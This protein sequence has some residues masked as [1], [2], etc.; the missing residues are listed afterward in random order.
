MSKTLEQRY[1]MVLCTMPFH[2]DAH[3]ATDKGLVRERNEDFCTQVPELNLYVLADGM[4]GHRAGN[5]AS[6]EATAKLCELLDTYLGSQ[7]IREQLTPDQV[8]T[9][10]SRSLEEVNHHVHSLGQNS[11]DLKGMGTTLCV[12]FFHGD[13]VIYGHVGDSRIYR[14]REY[15]LTQLTQDHSL[16]RDL[17]DEGSLSEEDVPDFD[18]KHVITRA[19]GIDFNVKPSVDISE[20]QEDDLY[21]MCTDGLSDYMTHEDMQTIITEAPTIKEATSHLIEG[22]NDLGGYDNTTI[23]MVKVK[24]DG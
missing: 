6:Q 23:V 1:K 10:I 22:A 3:L 13:V 21:V 14:Y 24:E 18:R 9:V 7:T 8:A 19:I 11:H 15:Q 5:V 17:L 2:F 16:M 12:L 4:G 20:V